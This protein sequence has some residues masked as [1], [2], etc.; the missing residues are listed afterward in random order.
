MGFL[1]VGGSPSYGELIS[2]L[3]EVVEKVGEYGKID[4]SNGVVM[5]VGIGVPSADAVNAAQAR[6][7]AKRAAL[8]A[9]QR[10]LLEA[11][12]GVRFDSE[13]MVE[14]FIAASD[15]MLS[16]VQGIVRGAT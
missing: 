6:T 11:L 10:N 4:W 3:S 2:P 15:R 7:M 12:R 5:A 13:T 9:A 1:T 8:V 16:A 14:N